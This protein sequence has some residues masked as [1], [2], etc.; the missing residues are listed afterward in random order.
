MRVLPATLFA[1]ICS[2]SVPALA[3]QLST[4]DAGLVVD[5][6][7]MGRFALSYP[8][9]VDKQDKSLKPIEKR[10]TGKQAVLKYEGG[11]EVTLAVE[12][13]DTVALTLKGV[14]A[15]IVKFRMDMLIDFSYADGGKWQIG[16]G[17]PTAF[18]AQ[19]P[20]K[21]FLFQGNQSTLRLINFE[22]KQLSFTIPPYSYQQL[23]D[24]RE[25]NWKIFNWSFWAPLQ[26]NVSRYT[27]QIAEGTV[28]G[29]AQRVVVADRFGQDAQLDF[30]G[31]VKSEADLKQDVARDEA[32]YGSLKPPTL[33]PFGGLPDSGAT[34]GLKRTGF[35][36]VEKT[37]GRW[38]MVDPAGN[39]VFHLGLC[40]FGPSDDYTYIKGREQIYE[41]LP[42]YEGEY[43]TA[44][45][46]DGY[47]S[48]DAFSFY[49]ANVVRKHGKP[50]DREEWMARM[51]PRVRKLGFN[52]T[53]AFSGATEAH[54]AAGFPY[55]SS[56]PL[57]EWDLGGQIAGL[58]G[59]FDPFDAK[60]LA[61]MDELFAERVAPKADEP[62]IIGYF[63][64]NE[65]A[66]ED[67]PRVIPTLKGSQPAKQRLLQ[68]L[69]AK[70]KTVADFNGA[71]GMQAQSFDALKDA[72]LPVATKEAAADMQAFTE[73]FLTEYFR[74]IAD[75]FHKYDR[76][77]LL[78]GNRWQPGTANNEL[79]CR[80]A[81]QYVD[82]I[83]LNYY[84]YGID[85]PFLDRLHGWT[86]DKPMMLSEFYWASPSDTGLPGGKE[87]RNQRERGLAYRNYVEQTAA[88]PYITGVEWFTLIDQARTGRW[89]ER[90]NGENA[91]SGLF[92]VADRP[93]RDCLAEMMKTNYDV[94]A[95]LFGQRPAFVYDDPKFTSAG[96]ATKTV[97]IPRAE[98]TLRLD[99]SREGWPGV[100]P[101]RLS[102]QRLVEGADAGGVEGVF[103]LCWDD[104]N[105]YLLVE[106]T[107]P[108]P[109]MNEHTGNSLWA[110]DGVELFLGHEQVD[111]PGPLLFTDRQV[112]LS[113]G[114]PEGKPRTDAVRPRT[115]AVRPQWYYANAPKQYPC[116][117]VVL[118][119]V[120][121][122]GYVLEAALPFEA[123]GIQPKA[124]QQLLFDLALDN[125]TDGKSRAC[126]LM[127]NGIA[128][129]SG[130]R[131]HWGRAVL[132][133]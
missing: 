56:L 33:D 32:Y 124:G 127:W 90:Y 41:W 37:K 46:P 133:E 26:E 20:E 101:E 57:S 100:P 79:L 123:F 112:L 43:R 50:Y 3:A 80:I 92:N 63:L 98:G 96:A 66:F 114:L 102:S 52:A 17:D 13:A 125:S 115:D 93:H 75:A 40:G 24:N 18:P 110:A 91:N 131:T 108:T 19:K 22:G 109:M 94:Y 122:T 36:H 7:S 11:A 132:G 44:F 62:L 104:R 117:L 31:K 81:G 78:L 58:R 71:W 88:L 51:I 72:G 107:D 5:A 70:H 15:E 61:K 128:R 97:K 83:S 73:L 34:V 89:F 54:K 64:A 21:P 68:M 29:G 60:T 120:D 76:N 14:P 42:P 103:R 74:Q 126:Q 8:E 6:G 59:L 38:V 25:W 55:V 113:A 99:G 129:N 65:Q 121:G 27:L 69:E 35:F 4:T 1:L 105:L 39:A 9:L 111:Q 16:G 77:H 12:A 116:D 85:K 23:Q 82:V 106:V 84:T 95:V 87:V 30:P 118:P 2:C 49:L 119:K 130:D 10:A 48:R 86:G 45:H 67:V 28:A 53:G 47:W